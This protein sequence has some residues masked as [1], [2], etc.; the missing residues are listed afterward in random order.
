[1]FGR[2]I[3]FKI[4]SIIDWHIVFARKY[5]QVDIDNARKKYKWVRNEYKIGDL[6][7]LEEKVI[8]RKLDYKK[9]GPYIIAEVFKK[10][11]VQVQRGA[12]N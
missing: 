6:I 8:Y 11:T 2:N 4:T 1:M 12:I 5:Q 10:D 3:L 9:Q 7:Y